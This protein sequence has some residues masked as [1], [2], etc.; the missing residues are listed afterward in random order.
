MNGLASRT[1]GPGSVAGEVR[2][3]DVP[4]PLVRALSVAALVGF[5]CF[6]HVRTTGAVSP[7]A[8]ALLAA[9]VATCVLSGGV[10]V[11]ATAGIVAWP[12][13]IAHEVLAGFLIANTL[14]FALTLASPL[15]IG[16]HV[17]AVG[18]TAVLVVL[19]ARPW[20]SRARH[21]L[22]GELG[23]LACIVFSGAAATL[24]VHDQQPMMTTRDGSTVFTVWL[25]VF[26]HARE[27]SAFAQAHGLGS[28]SDIK[29]AGVPAA[30]YH[31]ASYMVPAALNALTPT[32]AFDSYAAFQLPFGIM[33]VGIAGYALVAGVLR[34]TWPAVIASGALVALPDAYQ[35]GFGIRLLSF[36]FMSQVNLGMLYGI[37]CIATAWLFMIEACRRDR[38][39]GVVIAYA[40]LGF[41]LTYKA[42]LFVANALL[43]MLYPCALFGRFRTRWRV[44][45]AV[46]FT[47]L[48]VQ[49]VAISQAS[50][51]VPVLRLD[52][53]GLGGYVDILLDSFDA[54]AWKDAFR[55]FHRRS[56][57]HAVEGV[58]AALLIVVAS[59]G[60]WTFAAPVVSWHA[61]R[62]LGSRVVGF[63]ALVVVNYLVMSTMLAL[64]DRGVG[65]KEE[66]VNR[67]HAWAYFV[68]VLFA[69]AGAALWIDERKGLPRWVKWSWPPLALAALLGVHRLAPNLQTFPAWDGFDDYRAFNSVPACLTRSAQYVRDHG[70]LGDVLLDSRLDPRFV[71]SALSER[72]S[73]V[74]SAEF[75]G[76]TALVMMR[77]GL[78]ESMQA[79]GDSAALHAFARDNGIGWYLLHPED[80]AKFD[81]R[82]LD[83]AAFR[84]DG[85][86]VFRFPG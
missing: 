18:A 22:H 86:R 44:L 67:P 31:F 46:L 69:V 64:D 27:I 1:D 55:D 28:L 74:S 7:K 71:A 2:P 36:H 59:F 4:V 83:G 24:W 42:H 32:T 11:R 43:L 72:Q 76:H 38:L 60:L 30:A 8:F 21:D 79:T 33:L 51:R 15:G 39:T 58:L 25:D 66:I 84:C 70:R 82:F 26:I 23:S 3:H 47:V 10:F 62:R 80:A 81:S 54:G 40:L 34:T 37:A 48:F 63:V 73:F 57:P 35:Q 68:V 50:P 77:R 12:I 52:G 5:A 49:V 78:V 56:A 6:W 85:Y 19:M 9:C 13:G 20:R 16:V 41:C 75:G 61:R 17:A 53:S 14:L 65:A 45:V 29:L